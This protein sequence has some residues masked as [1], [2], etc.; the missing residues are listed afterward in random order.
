MFTGFLPVLTLSNTSSEM[1]MMLQSAHSGTEGKGQKYSNTYVSRELQVRSNKR[2]SNVKQNLALVPTNTVQ[3][4]VF[5][6]GGAQNKQIQAPRKN[7]TGQ[8]IVH[9]L[10]LWIKPVD[11]GEKG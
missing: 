9:C 1:R 5:Q 4:K 2:K 10:K 3:S 6:E 7:K 11:H 8:Q